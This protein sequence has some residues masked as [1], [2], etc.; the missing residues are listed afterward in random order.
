[1]L[2]FNHFYHYREI[3]AARGDQNSLFKTQCIDEIDDESSS[4]KAS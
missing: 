3:N 4:R 2:F 1:M